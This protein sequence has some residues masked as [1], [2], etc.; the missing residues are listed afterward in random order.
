MRPGELM[1]MLVLRQGAEL[2]LQAEVGVRPVIV[3]PQQ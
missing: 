3:G 1:P 2:E